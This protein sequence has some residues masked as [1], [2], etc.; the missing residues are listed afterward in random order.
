MIGHFQRAILAPKR[1]LC[2]F[3]HA[4][5]ASNV[6]LFKRVAHTVN[7]FFIF[8]EETMSDNPFFLCSHF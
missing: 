1:L 5:Y 4:I 8:T 2:I 3:T 6:K 7:K